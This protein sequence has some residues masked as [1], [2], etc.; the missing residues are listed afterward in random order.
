ML[1]HF[2]D[3]ANGGSFYAHDDLDTR[4]LALDVVAS[5]IRMLGLRRL[6]GQDR[7]KNRSSPGLQRAM[8]RVE[9]RLRRAR[10]AGWAGA[11]YSMGTWEVLPVK[12]F[13]REA[14][15][16]PA[17]HASLSGLERAARSIEDA[18]DWMTAGVD[19]NP[20]HYQTSSPSSPSTPPRRRGPA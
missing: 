12:I 3:W 4:D 10:S 13:R 6:P 1:L 15:G 14:D 2:Q 18:P 9:G 7:W 20:R 16:G 5:A 17:S 8:W 19:V 11:Q